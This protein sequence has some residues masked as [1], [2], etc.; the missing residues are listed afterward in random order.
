MTF[1]ERLLNVLD[2]KP[3]DRPPVVVPTQNATVGAM[4][5]V[6]V[7]WPD[8]LRNAEPM[9]QLALGLTKVCGY[10]AIRVP[11]DINI[12]AESMGCDTRYG[13]ESDPPISK[14]KGR[15]TL[16]SLIYPDP[17]TSGRMA[18]VIKAVKIVSKEKEADMPLIAALGTPFEVLCTV[19]SFEEIFEDIGDDKGKI[20]DMLDKI[21][22]MQTVYAKCLMDAGVDVM[23]VV[24]GTS[25]T[26]NPGLFT[27]FSGPYTT[28]LIDT[29]NV[30]SILH[31]CGN[32]S[33]VIKEMAATGANGLSI[34]FPVDIQKARED[35]EGK[36]ALV[37]N[38]NVQQLFL[39]SPD[40]VVDMV[41]EVKDAGLDII[42]P[43]C[44]ILPDTPLVNIRAYV[45]TVKSINYSEPR[46][47]SLVN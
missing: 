21:L 24:D 16:D 47:A 30:P 15:N 13:S 5:E 33:K 8:A 37:G 2:M 12:E 25:Q 44:G 22:A 45:D 46:T 3:V 40:D 43:G 42:A 9:A 7:F 31:I 39:G 19:Y 26:L 32:P 41:N 23:M 20:F 27:E 34:D 29:F 11:F 36:C 35:L 17:S 18:E 38:L 10:E 28:K 14:P 1:K 6:G 4:K